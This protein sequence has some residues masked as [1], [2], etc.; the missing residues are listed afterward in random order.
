MIDRIRDRKPPLPNFG[1]CAVNPSK[2]SGSHMSFDWGIAAYIPLH[3]E[4][5]QW[6]WSGD[7]CIRYD[8]VPE[9][10]VRGRRCNINEDRSD[11][12]YCT[13]TVRWSEVFIEDTLAGPTYYW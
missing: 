7:S 13:K 11:P 10:Y 6:D 3:R 12:P 1:S 4:C 5:V 2:G 8:T 9:S